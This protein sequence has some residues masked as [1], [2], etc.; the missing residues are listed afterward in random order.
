[1]LGCLSAGSVVARD[2][3]GS[4]IRGDGLRM[5]DCGGVGSTT[6]GGGVVEHPPT[7]RQTAI[8][9]TLC[10]DIDGH[11]SDDGVGGLAHDTHPVDVL[12]DDALGNLSLLDLYAQYRD[13]LNRTLSVPVL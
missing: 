5:S 1:L 4:G 10:R 13:R 9:I 2:G 7:S 3:F 6:T 8:R 11:L 12:R